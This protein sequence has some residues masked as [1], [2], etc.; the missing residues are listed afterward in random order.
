[1]IVSV[2]SAYYGIPEHKIDIRD[3]ITHYFHIPKT[4]PLNTIFQDPC[5]LIQKH[6]NVVWSVQNEETIEIP[7]NRSSKL[8][9]YNRSNQTLL[10]FQNVYTYHIIDASFDILNISH[11]PSLHLPSNILPLVSP[12]LSSLDSSSFPNESSQA[13]NIPKEEW[14]HFVNENGYFEIPSSFYPSDILFVEIKRQAKYITTVYEMGGF[15][16]KDLNIGVE[17]PLYRTNLIYHYFPNMNHPLMHLH[18]AYLQQFVKLFNHKIIIS[19]CTNHNHQTF[20]NHLRGLLGH[21]PH[22]EFIHTINERH[23]GEG[24]S[25]GPLLQKVQS[26]RDDEYTYYAHTKGLGGIGTFGHTQRI[27]PV[28]VWTEMMHIMNISNLDSMIFGKANFGGTFFSRGHFSHLK[29]ADWHYVGSFYWIHQSFI[30]HSSHLFHSIHSDYYVSE[31][32]PANMC[33]FENNCLAFWGEY[34]AIYD[35]SSARPFNTIIQATSL[36]PYLKRLLH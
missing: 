24:K 2:E 30:N 31:Y 19:I 27:V 22:L 16:Y 21:H 10:H 6:I 18:H 5:P 25:F 26:N 8:I 34:G 14:Q 11:K 9:G 28:G 15:L 13:E 17:I 35:L 3:Y 7:I 1:M 33:K 4:A 23:V 12:N 36:S 32:Y 29:N 20:E